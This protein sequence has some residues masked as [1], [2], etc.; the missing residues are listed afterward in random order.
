[1]NKR[2]SHS[3]CQHRTTV[4]TITAGLA[5]E[6]CETCGHVAVR[7]I[8]NAVQVFNS[9][10]RSFLSE[11]TGSVPASAEVRQ[12][13]ESCL[14]CRQIAVYSIPDGEV[15]GEHAWQ[16]AARLDWESAEIWVP[17]RI[18]RSSA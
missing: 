15:C 17:I 14:H 3:W 16:A 5:R 10:P 11:T 6:V 12:N 1:M 8:E 13:P 7:Y 4:T 9:R 18:D 2:W